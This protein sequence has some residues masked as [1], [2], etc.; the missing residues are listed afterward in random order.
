MN[1][2]KNEIVPMGEAE[3]LNDL[4]RIFLLEGWSSTYELL[5]DAV[6]MSLV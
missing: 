4:A 3:G 5:R 2:A 1:L 6:Q